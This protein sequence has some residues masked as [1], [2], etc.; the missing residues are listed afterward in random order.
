MRASNDSSFV[1][2]GL[3]SVVLAQKIEAVISIFGRGV[4]IAV[5]WHMVYFFHNSATLH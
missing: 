3:W 1:T 2:P 5:L 4:N